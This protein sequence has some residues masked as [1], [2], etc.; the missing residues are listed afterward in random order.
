MDI[1]DRTENGS[2]EVNV[3]Q[4]CIKMTIW[5]IAYGKAAPY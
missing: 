4:N 1:V 2:G 3:N 5:N